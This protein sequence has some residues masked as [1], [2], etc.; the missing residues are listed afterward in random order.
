MTADGDSK[1]DAAY[2][3]LRR[4]ILAA[5][6]PADTALRPSSLKASYGLSWTPVR[7]AL[8]RLEA[9]RLVVYRRNR[10]FAVAPVS[11]E[12][13]DDLQRARQA[14]ELPLLKEA[15]E[16]GDAE[17]EA[18]LVAA[19]HRLSR[20]TL[21]VDDPSEETLSQWEHLHAAFHQTLLSAAVSKWLLRFQAQIHEQLQRH[22]RVLAILPVFKNKQA[23]AKEAFDALRN[24]MSTAHHTELLHAVLDR[25]VDRALMLMA[26]HAGTTMDVFERTNAVQ[27]QLA[28]RKA[29]K[30]GKPARK[31]PAAKSA[32]S[33]AS[34]QKTRSKKQT[35]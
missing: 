34:A 2:Q 27:E 26:E 19:H 16:N 15:I 17:W 22:H 10:G 5:R 18:S 28:R 29:S 14:I 13:L 33:T 24:A 3:L 7:E 11:S 20:C 23:D 35:G 30:D 32:A 21:P 31:S 8:A 4:E 6:L 25:D 1:T 9:E 12:E